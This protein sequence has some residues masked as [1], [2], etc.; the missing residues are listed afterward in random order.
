MDEIDFIFSVIDS[1]AMRT[2]YSSENH[3]RSAINTEPENFYHTGNAII[4][5]Q[6]R[7]CQSKIEHRILRGIYP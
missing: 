4:I 7:I 3:M 1:S 6:F 2:D 5:R